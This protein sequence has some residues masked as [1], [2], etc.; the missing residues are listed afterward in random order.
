[1]V[2]A[3]HHRFIGSPPIH[4]ATHIHYFKLIAISALAYYVAVLI[5]TLQVTEDDEHI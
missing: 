5:I 1:M 4:A 3:L 2:K